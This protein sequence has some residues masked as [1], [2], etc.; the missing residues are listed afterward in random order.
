MRLGGRELQ[1]DLLENPGRLSRLL[2]GGS[3][4]SGSSLDL[5]PASVELQRVSI[6]DGAPTLNQVQPHPLP[7]GP[8]GRPPT[9]RH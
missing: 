5:R 1:V 2:S 6:A 8:C 7:P 4:G 9:H 3:T